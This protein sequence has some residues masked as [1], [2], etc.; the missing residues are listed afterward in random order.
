MKNLKKKLQAEKNKSEN[1]KTTSKNSKESQDVERVEQ[2]TV[3]P[4]HIVQ[5]IDPLLAK[6]RVFKD[7]VVVN[8]NVCYFRVMPDVMGD[9]VE[10]QF[11]NDQ[12][13]ISITDE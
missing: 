4:T 5:G 6:V 2:E 9:V 1:L 8:D 10:V 11:T 7:R 12:M 3:P 13:S